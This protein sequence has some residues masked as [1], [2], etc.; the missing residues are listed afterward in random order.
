MNNK[1]RKRGDRLFDACQMFDHNAKGFRAIIVDNFCRST[2]YKDRLFSY[3]V[4]PKKFIK[5]KCCP[6]EMWM[7][8]DEKL[9][10]DQIKYHKMKINELVK[11]GQLTKLN[12][13][14]RL[15]MI[16]KA[17]KEEIFK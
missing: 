7:T 1:L 2:D 14:L 6:K 13:V 9:F 16:K 15:D 3:E 11:K 5:F 12:A 10:N 4:E 8:E 17:L